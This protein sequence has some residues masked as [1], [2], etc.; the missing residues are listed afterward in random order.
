MKRI[1]GVGIAGYGKGFA[2]SG[3]RTIATG[4]GSGETESD[5]SMRGY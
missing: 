4:D 5:V 3:R 2:T 1:V